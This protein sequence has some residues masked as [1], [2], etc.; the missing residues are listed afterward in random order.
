MIHA[1]DLDQ[2][3]S[4]PPLYRRTL[5]TALHLDALTLLTRLE[6]LALCGLAVQMAHRQ[7]PPPLPAGPGGAPRVY[8]EERPL[9]LALL[10]ALA[11][12]LSGAARLAGGRSWR[13]RVACRRVPTGGRVKLKKRHAASNNPLD[14]VTGGLR[15]S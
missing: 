14:R 10:R 11:P 4:P 1:G 12:V 9:L 15:P 13:W 8:T 6:L 7:C 5:A 2:E 3:S